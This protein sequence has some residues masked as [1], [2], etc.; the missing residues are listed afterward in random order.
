MKEGQEKGSPQEL[1]ACVQSDKGDSVE[2]G[3]DGAVQVAKP[4]VRQAHSIL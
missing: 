2:S 3:G 4:E 1:Q